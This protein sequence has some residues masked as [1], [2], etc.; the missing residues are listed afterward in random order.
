MNIPSSGLDEQARPKLA[1]KARLKLDRHTGEHWLI[2]P[3]RGMRLNASA[4]RIAALCSGELPLSELIER[5]AADSGG[6]S[7]AQIA[8]E[9]SEFL[10]ALAERGLLSWVK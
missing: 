9:A 7:R 3:E 4:A 8:R 1:R 10:G 5:L 6:A 2:Y